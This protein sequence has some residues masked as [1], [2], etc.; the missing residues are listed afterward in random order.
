GE[1]AR[2]AD[3]AGRAGLRAQA[4][5]AHRAA[6][7]QLTR[8]LAASSRAGS[9]PDPARYRARGRSF[10]LLGDFDRARDD[11]ARALDAARAA[12]DRP[13][14][15][16]CLVALGFLWTARDIVRAGAYF[17]DALALARGVPAESADPAL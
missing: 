9:P 3:Y 4:L 2:A 8:A 12:R 10:E 11:F 5:H 14:E 13:V 16:R 7:D 15:C 17:Q 1:W 6:I